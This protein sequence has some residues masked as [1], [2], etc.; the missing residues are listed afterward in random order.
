[1]KMESTLD[2]LLT[3][4]C[5]DYFR[6]E[7]AIAS[8]C[9]TRRT[10][11]EYRYLNERILEAAMEQT[12]DRAEALAYIAE[13]GERRGYA[14]ADQPVSETTYKKRKAEIRAGILRKLHL[15]D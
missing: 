15:V 3:A 4:L 8:G 5:A 14:Y 9:G 6:R 2:R 11:M 13:I 10:R 7:D 1:M 12:A